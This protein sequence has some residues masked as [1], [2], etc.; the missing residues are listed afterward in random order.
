MVGL[1]PQLTLEDLDPAS[2][3]KYSKDPPDSVD[4]RDLSV[5]DSFLDFDSI[6]DWFK[7]IDMA[8]TGQFKAEAVDAEYIGGGFEPAGDGSVPIDCGSGCA[9]KVEGQMLE[10]SGCLIAEGLGKVNLLGGCEESSVLDGGNGMKSEVVS[11]DSGEMKPVSNENGSEG[12]KSKI[13]GG[14]GMGSEMVSGNSGKSGAGNG[15]SESESSESESE[16]SSSSSSSES[17]NSSDDDSSDDEE[18]E[19]RKGKM[20]VEVQESNEGGEMEE[21]EIR[22]ADGGEEEDKIFGMDNESEDDDDEDEMVAWA[23]AE[24]FDE[25][26]GDEDDVGDLKGPIRSKNELEVLPPIPPVEVTLQ[27]HHQMQPVGVVLSVLGTQ[28][29][30]EGV[31]KHNPLNEG[32]ILWVTES[33]SPLGLID[34]I[35][36]PVIQPYYVVRYNSESEIPSGI[37]TGILVSFVPEFAD[38]VL[39]NKDVYRKGYDASGANDEEISDEAEFSDDE[40]EAEYRRMQKMSKRGMND[41]NVGNKKNNRKW[42]KNK[43]GPWKNGQPS[44]QQTPMDAVK[45][46]PNQHHHPFSPGV[47]SSAAV[48]QGLVSRTGLVPPFPA[49]TQ[50]A[51]INTT[52]NGGWTNGVPF[53]PQNTSFPNGFPNNSFPSLP[54][55]NPQYPYQ[56]SIPNRMPFYQQPGA[57][58]P[59]QQLNAFAGPAYSQGMMGQHGFNQTAFGLGLQG[60]PIPGRQFNGFAEP[61]VGQLGFNPNTFGMGLQGQPSHPIFNADQGMPSNGLHSEQNHNLPQSVANAG[62]VDSQQCNQGAPS[63][64]GRRPS[65]RGGRN[66]GRGRGRQQSR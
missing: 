30:V 8:E 65:R 62:N 19:N 63:N 15:E 27:P 58:L 51:G 32:S 60:Q 23:D 24:T 55:Y 37:Q 28:V 56:M 5:A 40:K 47:P 9:V 16:S 41:Q 12:L 42:G 44:P 64:H 10:N 31:E 36:G 17:S 20:N 61:R 48:S 13:E 6:E 57:V 45:Q 29:I 26:D 38:H 66:F 54:Q 22:D 3:P 59:G 46:P 7:N 1:I 11:C 21:G 35:F 52:S 14:N 50:V 34:E 2:K 49:P 39:N 18:E 43:P 4:P 53:Q 33:R 25:G